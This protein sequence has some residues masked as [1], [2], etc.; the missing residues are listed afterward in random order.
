[1]KPTRQSMAAPRLHPVC[2]AAT[3][4]I[5]GVCAQ[6]QGVTA[7]AAAASAAAAAEEASDNVVV[8]TAQRRNEQLQK[9]PVAVTALSAK[10][11][12]FKQIRRMDDLKY[13]SL[14]HISEP[15]RPY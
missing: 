14:I 9:V 10:E 11:L 15:T 6:A 7:P 2:L 5:W 4:A 12:E 13:L 8:I 3:L 1:M